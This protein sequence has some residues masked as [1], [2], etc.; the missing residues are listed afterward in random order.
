MPFDINQ[1]KVLWATDYVQIAVHLLTALVLGGIIGFERSYHGRPAGFRTHT[2]VCLASSLLMMITFYQWKWLPGVPLDTVRTDP[3]R[4]AQGIMTG[5]G[6]LGAGV[7]YKEG[8]SVRG[9]TTAASI[10]ITAAIGILLGV[11]FYFPAIVA[12]AL[13]L[14][15]LSFFRRIEDKMPSNFYA[16]HTLS[17]DR[18]KVMPEEEVR[19]LLANHGFTVANMSYRISDD[20]RSFE[21]RMAIGTIDHDKIASLA[22]T[23]R[24]LDQVRSFRISPTGD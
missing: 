3:T 1:L 21:Y 14:G 13:T 10:W 11:G 16:H 24:K 8:R 12:S 4:M 18:N 22:K 23:L 7:I 15:V 2:L 17:F 6:F 19:V 5:I 9:L 20:G